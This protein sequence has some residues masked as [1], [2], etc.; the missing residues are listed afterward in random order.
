MKEIQNRNT[1]IR[2]GT[3]TKFDNSLR[4]NSLSTENW[5]SQ[6]G[7]QDQESDNLLDA[8]DTEELQTVLISGPFINDIT[9]GILIASI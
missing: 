6:D 3:V 9:F 1:S 4:V 2:L 7:H 8:A 5:A